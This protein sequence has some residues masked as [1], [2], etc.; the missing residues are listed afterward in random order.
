MNLSTYINKKNC[1][2]ICYYNRDIGFWNMFEILTVICASPHKREVYHSMF[3]VQLFSE[4]MVCFMEFTN[5]LFITFIYY[6][7]LQME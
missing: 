2:Q 5:S 7:H 1:T 6:Y 4:L 3:I